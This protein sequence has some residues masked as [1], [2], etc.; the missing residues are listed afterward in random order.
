[1]KAL[2]IQVKRENPKME[3]SNKS[4]KRVA[5]HKG[6][7]LLSYWVVDWLERI[8]IGVYSILVF[9]LSC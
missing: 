8:P 4:H 6:G 3:H 7:G 5:F 1:M 2:N 9:L